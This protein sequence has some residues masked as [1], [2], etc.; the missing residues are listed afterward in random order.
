MNNKEKNQIGEILEDTELLDDI[1]EDTDTIIRRMDADL[2]LQ[3]Q[4]LDALTQ[5]MKSLKK[6]WA[7]I[8]L[9]V[10]LWVIDKAY[11][12]ACAHGII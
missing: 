10:A 6:T 12:W 7:G 11:V 5:T 2:K 1:S 8:L 3:K 9:I 4:Q